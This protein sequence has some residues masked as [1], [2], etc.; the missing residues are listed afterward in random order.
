MR[1]NSSSPE[2]Q[3]L[4]NANIET[5]MRALTDE[6]TKVA[7]D[8]AR[9]GLFLVSGTAVA[10]FIMAIASVLIARFLGPELYGQYA[11]ALVVPQILFIFT[12]LGINQ[13]IIKFI[14]DPKINGGT[15]EIA[16][17]VKHGLM[18][19]AFAGIALF[20]INY[21]FAD[22]FASVL[23]QRPDL[24]FYVRLGSTSILLQ[25]LFTTATSAFVGIDKTEYSALTTNV[26]ALAKT[27]IS[28]TLVLLGF[29]V[30]GAIIGFI[31]SYVIAAAVGLFFL[32]SILRKKQNTT[33][34]H[35]FAENV[36]VLLRYGTPLYIAA[37]LVGF[38]PLFQNVMLAF[39]TTDADIG[40]YKAAVNFATL[41]TVFSI[42]I[43]TALLA[44]FSKLNSNTRGEIK[45]FFKLANKYTSI[46]IIPAAFLIII[47]S[48]EVVQTIY[49]TT[50]QSASVFLA[51]YCLLY[52][53]VGFGHLTLPSFY[54][55]IGETKTTLK[56][57]LLTF[58]AL[59]VFSP[60]LTKTYNV[61]GLI[62]AFLIASTIG[63]LY[64]SYVAMKKF[65]VKF[66]A[67]ILLKVYAISAVSSVLPILIINFAGLPRLIGGAMGGAL[68][69]LIYATLLPVTRVV[70]ASEL[71]KA[72]S[73]I[74]NV[75]LLSLIAKPILKYQQ[76][77]LRKRPS[78]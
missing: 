21:T 27:I 34:G 44:A 30:A 61:Q 70:T 26:Q 23:L 38:I 66:E 40:N 17:I 74:Q 59:A 33:A 62:V 77:I 47:F 78:R 16:K 49:G 36:R 60:L 65:Q 50:Y 12:D 48:N 8:S 35:N 42:P 5:G 25:V 1:L 13:G 55:G 64:G 32:F 39:F 14:A 46:I 4:E 71:Q 10:T 53:L 19:R 67:P 73:V 24:A 63:T 41:L 68:Y 37:L 45:A 31:A 9:G 15:R 72:M 22:V 58:S 75:R 3:R 69:L 29:S 76:K 54:N 56:M 28:V 57:S 52:L 20:L 6:L 2:P 43:T 51:T 18:L 7:E 11:L